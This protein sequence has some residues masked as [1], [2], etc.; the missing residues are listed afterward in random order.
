M[1]EEEANQQ[2][3]FHVLVIVVLHAAVCVSGASTRVR[4]N[5]VVCPS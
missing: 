5:C 2:P 3:Y 4:W 1:S